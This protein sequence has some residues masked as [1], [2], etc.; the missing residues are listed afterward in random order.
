MA[1]ICRALPQVL[2][3]ALGRADA[4]DDLHLAVIAHRT[5]AQPL[6]QH[7]NGTPYTVTADAGLDLTLQNTNPDA[8]EADHPWGLHSFTLHAGQWHHG[9]PEG[10][11]PATA[12]AQDVIRLFAP[13]PESSLVTP[14]MVCFTVPGLHEGQQWSVLCLFDAASQRLQSFSLARVGDWRT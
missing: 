7:H 13:D 4:Q 14:A 12:T 2:L 5:A 9:W 3:Q 8:A 10:L 1:E 6:R 11:N